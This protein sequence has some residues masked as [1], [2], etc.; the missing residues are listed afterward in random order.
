MPTLLHNPTVPL[1]PEAL[2]RYLTTGWRP[3]GQSLY[4]ADYLRTDEDAIYGC[5]Q[6]RV[7]LDDFTFKKRHRRLLKKNDQLFRVEV[8]KADLPDAQMLAVNKAYLKLHPEKSTENL[9]FHIIGDQLYPVLDTRVVK[10]YLKQKLLGFSFF[11]VGKHCLYSKAGIYDPAFA[12]YSLGIYTMLLEMR[13]ARQAGY[14]F[15]HPGYFAP[16]YPTFNYKLSFGPV[17]YRHPVHLRW[18]PL[19]EPPE[20]HRADPY[21]IIEEKLLLLQ[22]YLDKNGMGTRLLEYPS[23]TARYYYANADLDA[24][25]LLDSPLLL[26]F[27]HGAPSEE[28][29]AVYDLPEQC[30]RIHETAWSGMQDF[31]LRP[32]SPANGRVR[33]G[34]PVAIYET[35]AEGVTPATLMDGLLQRRLNG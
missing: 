30:Y 28:L 15:Y 9:A 27:Q 8:G 16:D 19:E 26:E 34:R 32:I 33:F 17:E 11:D 25:E 3:T 4:T 24:D 12:D 35:V 22:R 14:R 5:L 20:N 18:L 21:H 6:V 13:W 29:I 31:K 2:D 23:Y 1:T 10:V 7:P